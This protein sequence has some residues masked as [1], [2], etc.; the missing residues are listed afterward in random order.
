MAPALTVVA[1]IAPK[2][3]KA[4]AKTLS[5]S[6][7]K[8]SVDALLTPLSSARTAM[9]AGMIASNVTSWAGPAVFGAEEW[10]SMSVPSVPSLDRGGIGA[11]Q[12]RALTR[13]GRDQQ[14]DNLHGD[15]LYDRHRWKNH[16][17]AD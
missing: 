9:A 3:M 1:K 10:Q 11:A 13:T 7:V 5:A 14:A 8:G 16:R 17:V 2:E 6:N 4:P 15:Y 12:A